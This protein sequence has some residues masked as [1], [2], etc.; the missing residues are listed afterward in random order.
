MVKLFIM[1]VLSIGAGKCNQ[2][3]PEKQVS[4]L[5]VIGTQLS[6]ANGKPVVL[7]GISFG[8]HNWWPRFYNE[9]AVKE[10][11]TAFNCSVVRAAMGIEPRNGYRQNPGFAEEKIKA[12]V[13]A[14]IANNIYVIIDW[15]SH[16][17][18]TKEAVAF[19][20]KMAKAYGQFPHV[21]YE[22]FNEPDKETWP[23]VKAYSIEVI[24]AIRKHDPDNIILVGSP[25]WDQAVEL[26]AADPIEG[27]SN[28]MYTMHFYAGTHKQWLRDK[29]DKAM[30]KG[31]PIFVSECAG[32]EASGNGPI[33]TV[34]WRK[35]V[36]WMEARKISWVAWS[37]SDKNET[38]S[39]LLPQ[40]SATGPWPDAV[41]KPWAKMV[42]AELNKQVR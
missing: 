35:Y 15:H 30:A 34:E 29:T 8:W 14:A 22:V 24:K 1:L 23:E 41:L 5:S 18:Q 9:G 20:E 12:V 28:L 6:D 4:P 26:P 32:M 13:E 31:L 21:I 36:E 40:A 3:K 7:R 16:N 33:D 19:F 38:C 17:I 39:M 42:K 25:Q 37:L 2:F 11:A 10:L 27:F